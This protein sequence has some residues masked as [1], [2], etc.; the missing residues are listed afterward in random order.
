MAKIPSIEDIIKRRLGEEEP[1]HQQEPDI[2]IL[3]GPYPNDD[4]TLVTS[5][6][7]ADMHTIEAGQHAIFGDNGS[8]YDI[9]DTIYVM[10]GAKLTVRPRTRLTF[11]RPKAG[12]VV[13]GVLEVDS[14]AFQAGGYLTRDIRNKEFAGITFKGKYSS[15]SNIQG[16][17]ITCASGTRWGGAVRLLDWS[18]PRIHGNLV[19]DC[20]ATIGSAVFFDSTY[21]PDRVIRILE[22]NR[23]IHNCC[24]FGSV[25]LDIPYDHSLAYRIRHQNTFCKGIRQAVSFLEDVQEFYKAIRKER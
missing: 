3:P 11:H 22:G 25:H 8:H 19:S 18:E 10:E 12:I 7:I 2:P 21:D 16:T 4:E 14:A 23:L 24:F 9:H 15:E 13:Y 17:Q 5:Q 1:E 20:H 6:D